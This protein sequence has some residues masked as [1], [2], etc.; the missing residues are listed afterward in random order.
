[1]SQPSI[2]ID[3]GKVHDNAAVL[4]DLLGRSG[5]SLTAVTKAPLGCPDL[6]RTL[7]AAG[8]VTLADSRV[9]NLER[10]RYAGIVG[11]LLL[12]RSPMLSQ[13][14]RVVRSAD[15]SC[16]TEVAVLEGLSAASQTAMVRHGVIVMVELGDLREGVRPE[17]LFGVVEA[18]LLLPNLTLA[19]I[20]TNLAC[21]SGV[22][23]DERN[24]AQLSDLADRVEAEFCVALDVVSGGNSANLDWLMAVPDTG[25]VNNLRLGESVLLGCEPLHRRPLPGLHTDAVTISARSSNPN[26]NR[27]CRG[28]PSRSL[29]SGRQR[30]SLIHI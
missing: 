18:T 21:R 24:M 10:M 29:R 25:R 5:I 16:N 20:G 13:V 11:E 17:D 7:L 23:P 26:G 8:V 6:A 22:V 3:L 4:I 12:L 2:E 30:L 1:M 19:G 15:A 27:R 9:E 28:E 14:E